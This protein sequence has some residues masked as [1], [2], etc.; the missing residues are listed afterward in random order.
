MGK[1]ILSRLLR[2]V[3]TLVVII[4]VVFSLLRLM[5]VEGYFGA[6][7]DKLA[8]EVVD[9][10]LESIG[11]KDPL[12]KQLFD[13]YK[14]A[15]QGE[16]GKSINYRKNVDVTRIIAPKVKYSVYFGLASL[17][18]SLVVGLL[19]GVFMA[20]Y[21]GH[22]LDRVGTVYIVLINS[23]PSAVYYLFIQSKISSWLS[24][25]M[26][27][28]QDRPISWVLP[29]ISM[30]LGSIAS[31]A[32]WMRRYM[33]DELNKDYIR[34]A[35]AKG[36]GPRKTM[37]NH[38]LRNAFIPMAQYLPS[39]MLLTISGSIYVESLYSIPGMGGLLVDAIQKQDNPLVQI[40]VIVY[41]AIGIFG[42]V[43]GDIAMVIVDPRI[44]LGKKG[45][46]R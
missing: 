44:K 28:D 2:S 40:L 7:Y 21:K 9:A 26:I 43:L 36:I 22:A 33:V 41:S 11:L 34:L 1:Y 30:S 24:L 19:L 6:G 5:P 18:I 32:M 37:L 23:V 10:Y 17:G 39:S 45:G 20:R 31:Y 25:P 27:F 3:I 38:V 4:S 15:L 13:F 16:F 14:N 8:P 42:L 35:R 12:Y 29:V 46:N